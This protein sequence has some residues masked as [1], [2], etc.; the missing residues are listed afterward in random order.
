[1]PYATLQDLIDRYGEEELV[2]LTDRGEPRTG[3][4]DETVAGRAL[5]DA[6]AL[7][8][9]YVGRRYRL[10]LSSI[11]AQLVP[12]ACAIAR[13]GLWKDAAPDAVKA[14]FDAAMRTLRDISD[15]RLVL[16]VAGIEPPAAVGGVQ[17]VG[18]DRV[19]T[20]DALKDF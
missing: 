14:N 19:F 12:V 2:G 15:G 3:T 9:G 20:A 11:P 5:A 6:D 4:I 17:H 18:P 10:P 13:A 16:E 8:D 7:I 1:M